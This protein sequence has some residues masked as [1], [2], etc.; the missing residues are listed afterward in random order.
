M[1]SIAATSLRVA[2]GRKTHLDAM[3]NLIGGVGA[4]AVAVLTERL[5]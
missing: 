2:H 4:I 3:M 1:A 5:T